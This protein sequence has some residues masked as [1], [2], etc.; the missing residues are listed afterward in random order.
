[1]ETTTIYLSVK[2]CNPFKGMT[3]HKVLC[4]LANLQ[5]CPP[6]LPRHFPISEAVP[7]HVHLQNFA[8]EGNGRKFEGQIRVKAKITR[9]TPWNM[10]TLSRD[11]GEKVQLEIWREKEKQ[12]TKVL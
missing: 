1:M 10:T 6:A 2:I 9:M 4:C 11:E 5:L 8:S 12:M 3:F 7:Y